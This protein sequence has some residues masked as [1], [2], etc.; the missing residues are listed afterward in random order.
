MRT[1]NNYLPFSILKRTFCSYGIFSKGHNDK[2]ETAMVN[3]PL[4]FA[5]LKFYSIVTSLELFCQNHS[6]MG[7]QYNVLMKKSGFPLILLISGA[8]NKVI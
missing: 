7:S 8:L 5:P 2:F 6:N 1:N 4:V 3:E